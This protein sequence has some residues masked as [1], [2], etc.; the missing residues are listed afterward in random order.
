MTDSPFRHA[1]ARLV[2][3]LIDASDHTAGLVEDA[4]GLAP[5]AP[6]E[7]IHAARRTRVK[8]LAVLVAAVHVELAAGHG[9]AQVAEGLGLAEDHA[10]E[11]YEPGYLT[12]RAELTEDI[13]ATTVE[14][15]PQLAYATSLPARRWPADLAGTWAAITKWRS[16]RAGRG[17][18][19]ARP[20]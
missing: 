9:W 3:T 2:T 14:A 5:Y 7:L 6:G 18:S 16:R 20:R 8:S 11:L 10:R 17:V 19:S 4:A 1:L 12:W 13:A 15:F